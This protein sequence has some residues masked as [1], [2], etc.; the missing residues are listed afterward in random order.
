[1]GIFFDL[2]RHG[3]LL[4][5]RWGWGR[6]GRGRA[7][8]LLHSESDVVFEQ[9]ISFYSCFFLRWRIVY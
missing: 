7:K 6:G 5:L 1:M 8:V 4:F 9:S 3:V 2:T